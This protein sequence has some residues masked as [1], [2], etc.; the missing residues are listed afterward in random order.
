MA[1]RGDNGGLN[2][3]RRPYRVRVSSG[4]GNIASGSDRRE[5]TDK[6]D[7]N[8]CAT[9][10]RGHQR[11]SENELKY[12]PSSGRGRGRG[13]GSEED[14]E[15]LTTSFA[16][17]RH[18]DI[19]ALACSPASDIVKCVT[20]NE[21]AFVS[22]Y[23]HPP[24]CT[25]QQVLK[26]LVKILYVLV[27]S[28]DELYAPP[29]LAQILSQAEP[30]LRQLNIFIA[31]MAIEKKESEN[32]QYLQYLVCIGTFVIE[33]IPTSVEA[34]PYE[35]LCSVSESP[36]LRQRMAH[37]KPKMELMRGK[38]VVSKVE[39]QRQ[40]PEPPECFRDIQVLPQPLEL[41]PESQKPF[42]RANITI[43]SYKNWDHYLDVQ[44]R[45]LREDF[46][47][48]LREGICSLHEGEKSTYIHV[49]KHV[50]ILEPV[51]TPAGI[52]FQIQF[53]TTHLKVK[54][55][56][57]KR[58]I[59]GSLLCL[60]DDN[61]N[62]IIFATVFKRDPKLLTEG[63]I[64]IMLEGQ[65]YKLLNFAT[66]YVMAESSSYFEAYRHVLEG[67][68]QINPPRMPFG[69]YIVGCMTQDVPPPRY[70]RTGN[71]KFDLKPILKLKFPIQISA[72]DLKTWPS[73]R[74]TCLDESQLKALQLALGQE[75]S[76]IQ[77]PPGTGKTFIGLK[78][79]EI[80]LLNRSIFDPSRSSPILVLCY[81]NHALDQF[82]EL[83]NGL[84]GTKIARVG[85]RSKSPLLADCTLANL[86]TEYNEQRRF[87]PGLQSRWTK[88]KQRHYRE[89]GEIN[90]ILINNGPII[91]LEVLKSVILPLHYNQLCVASEPGMEI[92][93]WLGLWSM[94]AAGYEIGDGDQGAAA[95]A[96]M[97]ELTEGSH[98]EPSTHSDDDNDDDDDDELVEVDQEASL[99]ED[100]R[101]SEPE[102]T[103]LRPISHH[104]LTE[105][106]VKQSGKPSFHKD[107]SEWMSVQM[108]DRS[109]QKKRKI[110]I[111]NCPMKE[112]E[113]DAVK[114][115]L[116]L[117][118]KQ[119]WMLYRYWVQR[120]QHERFDYV[121]SSHTGS[122]EA[123]CK[124]YTSIKDE[125]CIYVL[126]GMDVVGMTTT[127][128]S[129]HCSLLRHIS[130]RIVIVEE[131][132]EVF[133][134]HVIAALLPS[135]QQLVM[136]GDHKQ[137]RPKPSNYDLE[138]N[139]NFNV[140]LF[141]RLINNK[142]PFVTLTS[143]HRMRP[144]IAHLICPHIYNH[145]ENS[146][147]VLKYEP[148]KGVGKDIY[149]IDHRW[150][151]LDR[152][153]EEKYS[154]V[155]T[156]EA[157]YMVALCHHLLRQ[158]YKPNQITM[159]TMYRGQLLEM[160]RRMKKADFGG[161][162]IA[163][164]DDFQGEENDIILLS[165]VRSNSRKDIGFLK[166]SN[167]ICVSLSRAKKGFYVIG[168]LS[169][170]R[171][172]DGTVWVNILLD[173]EK[174][175]CIGRALPLYC[176]NHPAYK[177]FIETPEDFSKCPEGG[178]LEKCLARLKCGHMCP[179]LCHPYDQEH[180]VCKCEKRCPK[181]LPCGHCCELRCYQCEK[182]CPP[183]SKKV[184]R[185]MTCGHSILLLCHKDPKKAFCTEVC[186]KKLPCG[187]LCKLKC[188]EPC[189][190]LCQVRIEKELSCGHTTQAKCSEHLQDLNC[191]APCSSK[192]LCDHTCHGTC[193]QC[194]NGRLHVR[195]AANCGRTLPCGHICDFPCTSNCPPCNK[196]CTNLCN[197]S[198]CPKKCHEPCDPCAEDC[199]W[200]C[201][202]FK[203]TKRCGELCDRPPCN[204]PCTK[205]LPCGHPCIGLCGEVCPILCRICDKDKVMEI[206]FGSE[207]EEDARFIQLQDCKHVLEV[208][209]LDTWMNES[210]S[211][212]QFKSCPK[213][214]TV[215]RRHLRYGN[216]VKQSLIDMES[217]KRM[218]LANEDK[219]LGE[220][221]KLT[222]KVTNSKNYDYI[223][224]T[225][226][227]IQALL[228]AR[229]QLSQHY[230]YAVQ[231]CTLIIPEVVRL[232]DVLELVTCEELSYKTFVVSLPHLKND[233]LNLLKVIQEAQFVFCDQQI[234]DIF[235]EL[236]RIKCTVEL[237]DVKF[238]LTTQSRVLK[239]SEE[240]ALSSLTC[241]ILKRGQGKCP[242]VTEV[243]EGNVAH[244]I[245]SL[246]KLYNL[247]PVT[248]SERIGIV[249]A[250]GPSQGH[251]F[252][253]P[254]G[255]LYYIAG[256][257][258]AMVKGKCPDCGNK[259]GGRL[260]SLAKGNQR[261]ML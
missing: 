152:S 4:R 43:G 116:L 198:Q 113:A 66:E 216:I 132:A 214:K 99:I 17:L 176:Q 167:R 121:C 10:R 60:S 82:L 165:L 184:L 228:S 31:C 28:N 108:N 102:D 178:C 131:A 245:A 46:M 3:C 226:E 224:G 169:M 105:Q 241:C 192:L 242:K 103:D 23:S 130:P 250:M 35:L 258:G 223:K 26:H 37:L 112:Q 236:R 122:Y 97:L 238:K 18:S 230:I 219:L 56:H 190:K 215:I 12:R 199:S 25:N 111:S 75:V 243:E 78:I 53:D 163:V 57:S 142:M 16:Y 90:S 209:S 217:I 50:C 206:F 21:I 119:R 191:N 183:C 110:G 85:G 48:P 94:S 158:G 145:I 98:E 147:N 70:L 232:L 255:H 160:R 256:C 254:D 225:I 67:L 55:E 208:K 200:Q 182:G 177:V 205:A 201:E 144:E 207:T 41:N 135:V 247:G 212:V 159:L 179:R 127:G 30:F 128:A 74:D 133:E 143:Q 15:P 151:E 148:I 22:A 174:R 69:D 150:P 203:C 44:Y 180:V 68:K 186:N 14:A 156:H 104:K 261:A 187:H 54:W 51:C 34:F 76:L 235:T 218:Q 5:E 100:D 137:L 38:L 73:F 59:Y 84:K 47:G 71:Q 114:D 81:T 197:H 154:H 107:G 32:V 210:E 62:T 124:K 93:I 172:N 185:D 220:V 166:T 7:G 96:D 227:L 77:G 40:D 149:F 233:I 19:A 189:S 106:K 260:Y 24:N 221:E 249:K 58:L 87:P 244:L 134:A 181:Q 88:I 194:R 240:Q 138:R 123:T 237:C 9:R 211:E 259:V 45:L 253:C 64:S 229:K 257:G 129:K 109:R 139:F 153:G 195:C 239:A 117:T 204:E 49:Y 246:S 13:R 61:F 80:L 95:V 8:S 234:Y 79:I 42:L 6:H 193:G 125:C 157:K 39:R 52:G 161:V 213:C 27:E 72:T 63:I 164:V 33:R 196:Q 251:W 118:N 1:D 89:M 252:K 29:I 136:I 175:H 162:R 171:G 202:H 231:N 11:P 126:R 2:S 168:N 86:L 146:E 140:S 91:E 170:F 173:M 115:V 20:D 222:K 101:I 155:N 65:C 83:V 92:S 120:L 36:H 188:S 248:E 141:E